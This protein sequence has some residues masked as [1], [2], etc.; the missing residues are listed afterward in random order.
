[1]SILCMD[2]N[3]D[4]CPTRRYYD[5]FNEEKYLSLN[6]LQSKG[7]CAGNS[8]LKFVFIGHRVYKQTS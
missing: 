6:E 2:I 3:D 8:Q 5:F 4:I 1:M 7:Q